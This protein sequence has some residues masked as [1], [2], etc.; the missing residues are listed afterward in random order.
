MLRKIEEAFAH[1]KV[2]T[3][4]ELAAFVGVSPQMVQAGV[5][6]LKRMGRLSE[7]TAGRIEHCV[8]PTHHC[9]SC[10]F[11]GLCLDDTTSARRVTHMLRPGSPS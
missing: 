3:M 1:K 8:N 2:W 4:Q 7:D 10:P 11:Q 5:E 6:Q 9:N